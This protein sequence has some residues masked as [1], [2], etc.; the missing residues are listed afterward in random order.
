MQ[1]MLIKATKVCY[2]PEKIAA[3]SE[4]TADFFPRD[5]SAS[6]MIWTPIPLDS[7]VESASC[8]LSYSGWLLKWLI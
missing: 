6:G 1:V 7:D 5:A 3:L 4:G 8:H 2:E